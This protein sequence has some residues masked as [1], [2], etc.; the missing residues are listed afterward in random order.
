MQC[1]C[2]ASADLSTQVNQK[3]D[4]EL[5]Y[6][7]CEKCGT[8]SEAVLVLH[9]HDVCWDVT[10]DAVARRWFSTLTPESAE[11]LF[12]SVTALQNVLLGDSDDDSG[13]LHT[14]FSFTF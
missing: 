12:Q 14:Q 9:G 4:A 1:S 3:C 13:D 11:E 8:I 2:G 5:R 10:G 6:C 7:A